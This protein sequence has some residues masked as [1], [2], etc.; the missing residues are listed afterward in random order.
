MDRRAGPADAK[1]AQWDAGRLSQDR[2]QATAEDRESGGVS[3]PLLPPDQADFV[4]AVA[5]R[6]VELLDER[7]QPASGLVDARTL[8]GMFGLS[9][10]AVYEHSARLGAVRLGT[11]KRQLVRFDVERARAAWTRGVSGEESQPP[12]PPVDAAQLGA[13]RR[14]KRSAARSTDGLLPVRGQDAA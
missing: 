8:A 7:H 3:V 12:K 9:V 1:A 4:E 10:S 2:S 5:R 13:R 6:V 11:G 14:R